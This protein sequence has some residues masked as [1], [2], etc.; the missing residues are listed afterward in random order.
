MATTQEFEGTGYTAKL[1]GKKLVITVPN[2]NKSQGQTKGYDKTGNHHAANRIHQNR[3]RHDYESER[4]F[5]S[6]IVPA[7]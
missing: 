7:A 4:M 3:R 5:P 1:T 6:R 2:I